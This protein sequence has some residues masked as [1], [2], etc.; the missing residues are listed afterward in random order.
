MVWETRLRDLLDQQVKEKDALKAEFSQHK[1]EQ[2]EAAH[3]QTK[4]MEQCM[5]TV[6]ATREEAEEACQAAQQS[7]ESKATREMNRRTEAFQKQLAQEAENSAI[8]HSLISC[9]QV[10]RHRVRLPQHELAGGK[11]PI[12]NSGRV[13]ADRHRIG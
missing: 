13:P 1:R 5:K 7:V 2:R 12:R 8:G 3:A 11:T 9:R 10:S 4:V 6:A